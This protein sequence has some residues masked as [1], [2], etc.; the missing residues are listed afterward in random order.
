MVLV[1]RGLAASL[2]A[3]LTA[4]QNLPGESFQG[5]LA[6]VIGLAG[7]IRPA[8]RLLGLPESSIRRWLAGA[9]PRR[10]VDLVRP[11]RRFFATQQ[12]FTSA[13][14]GYDSMVVVADVLY[15]NE[16][17]KNR[18]LHVGREI[19]ARRIQ[20]ILRAWLDGNDKTVGNNL[21]RAIKENYFG[22][23]GDQEDL[24]MVQIRQ[25]HRI[26]FE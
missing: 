16:V 17:R 2:T 18:H 6:H 23:E 8:G 4:G 13:Y 3:Y 10:P 14:N 19:P 7:G 15:S 22:L 25:V 24:A 1:S 11:V 20:A 26:Y 12:R 21:M 9:K 5:D